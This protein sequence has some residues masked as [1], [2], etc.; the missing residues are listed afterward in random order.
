MTCWEVFSG[1]KVPYPSIDLSD[2]PRLLTN[3]YRLE[4]PDNDACNS[5]M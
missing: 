3:G 2:L 1:G 4:K 5:E